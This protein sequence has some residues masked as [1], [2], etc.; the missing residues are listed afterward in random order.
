MEVDDL[1][2]GV[3]AG[4]GPA[5]GIDAD[6]SLAGQLGDGLFERLLH[7]AKAG[8]RLP[9]VEVGAVVAEDEPDVSHRTIEPPRRQEHKTGKEED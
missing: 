3:D 5:A 7:G 2:D 6:R 1:A 9:A 4:V 8:L